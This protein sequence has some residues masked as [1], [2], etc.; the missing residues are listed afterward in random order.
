MI[1]LIQ[2]VAKAQVEIKGETFSKIS[3]GIVI[4]LGAVKEDAESDV[5]KLVEKIVNLRIMKDRQGKMNLSI[6]DAK[7]AILVVSQF[8]LAADLSGGRRPS[9]IK[10]KEPV[11]A[12]RLYEFF[13]AKI[14]ERGVEV[15]TGK[16]G[17]NMEVKITNEG[18]VTI[19]ADSKKL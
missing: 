11:E 9:F 16:F 13:V 2:R 17:A 6:L 7:G 1:A 3:Q 12:K 5:E 18:P 8:T 10:A 15:K 19:I 14:K 4:L